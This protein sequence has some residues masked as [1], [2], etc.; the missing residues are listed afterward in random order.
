[1]NDN[2]QQRAPFDEAK[3][4]AG[5][6]GGDP[7][8]CE[9]LVR[10]FGGRM[11]AAARRL[12]QHDDDAHDCVQDAFLRAIRGMERFE[13]RAGIG[14][15]LHRIVVNLALNRLR[16]R[17][18]RS[19]ES[20]DELLPV[21][22]ED[23][24]RVEP[25]G[26]AFTAPELALE[27]DESAAMLD[28]LLARLPDGHRNVLLLRDVEEYSTEETATLLETTPGAVRVRLHRARAALKT[29]LESALAER[30]T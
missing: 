27:R 10:T 30:G 4:V 3:L 6:R 7:R 14:T 13:G 9:L 29:L 28:E 15:W 26:A 1:M 19:E 20:L 16:A 23:G 21:F 17:Q 12:L 24:F 5:L 11:Y 18:R 25:A 22:D 8:S 2:D